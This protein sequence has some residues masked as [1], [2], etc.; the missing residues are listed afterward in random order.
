MLKKAKRFSKHFGL[1]KLASDTDSDE[2][3]TKE[4][5]TEPQFHFSID[6][7]STQNSLASGQ[8]SIA[9]NQSESSANATSKTPSSSS[10][11]APLAELGR[12]H[13]SPCLYQS[14]DDLLSRRLS[15][16]HTKDSSNLELLLSMETQARLDAQAEKEQKQ[17]TSQEQFMPRQTRIKFELPTTPPRSR[18]PSR[19]AYPRARPIRSLQEDQLSDNLRRHSVPPPK[20]SKR[21]HWRQLFTD[22]ENDDADMKNLPITYESRVRLLRRP[23]PTFGY[24]RYVGGVHFGKGEWI[25]IELDHGVGNC[26]GT[27]DGKFYFE[28]DHNRG[29]FCKRHDLE[30]APE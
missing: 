20:K 19:L 25:G 30:A 29:I 3:D 5:N 24:V 23:L 17:K 9:S 22:R 11:S 16:V 6:R 4:Q 14:D 10:L 2:E 28:A 13:T 1:K 12:S 26:N 8:N 27:I 15:Q 7:A 18:S 21:P